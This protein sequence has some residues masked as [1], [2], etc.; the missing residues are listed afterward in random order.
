MNVSQL[1]AC[2]KNL[3]LWTVRKNFKLCR[4]GSPIRIRIQTYK[5]R[6]KSGFRSQGIWLEP[7]PSLCPGSG[8][9]LNISLFICEITWN[10]TS[11]DVCSKLNI[12]YE[13]HVLVHVLEHILEHSCQF[14]KIHKFVLFYQELEPAPD[15]KIPEPEPPQN[16]P[17]P[18]P[19]IK[20]EAKCLSLRLLD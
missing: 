14:S 20:Y 13:L 3:S 9:T 4:F 7:E 6:I 19:W 10:L 1:S 17:T 18:K 5:C 16:R 2:N 8:S 15:K 12:K 11:F